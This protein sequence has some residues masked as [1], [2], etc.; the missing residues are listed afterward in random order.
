MIGQNLMLGDK[1]SFIL[2]SLC[3]LAV[4]YNLACWLLTGLIYHN[5][6]IQ[7]LFYWRCINDISNRRKINA[8]DILVNRLNSYHQNTKL[9]IKI[10]PIK[11]FW[12]IQE[13][14]TQE[15]NKIVNRWVIKYTKTLETRCNIWW[16]SQRKKNIFKFWGGN[17]FYQRI[18]LEN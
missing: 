3:I 11:L 18:I 17:Q 8:Q 6:H 13:S 7:N 9:A 14:R 10:T 5:I 2:S 12:Y 15:H 16:S 4:S 1:M